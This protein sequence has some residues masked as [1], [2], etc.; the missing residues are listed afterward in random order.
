MS[1]MFVTCIMAAAAGN[2]GP[3]KYVD[4]N[5]MAGLFHAVKQPAIFMAVHEH[6]MNMSKSEKFHG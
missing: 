1:V 2:V 6:I 3:I 4:T 5:Q